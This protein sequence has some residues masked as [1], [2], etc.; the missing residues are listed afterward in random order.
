MQNVSSDHDR[1]QS[2]LQ[3]SILKNEKYAKMQNRQNMQNMQNMQI[4]MQT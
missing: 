4:N 3:S 1:Q 2:T